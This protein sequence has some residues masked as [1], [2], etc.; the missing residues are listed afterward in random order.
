M[1][2]RIGPNLW[3]LIRDFWASIV[4]CFEGDPDLGRVITVSSPSRVE[5]FS[6]RITADEKEALTR[7]MRRHIPSSSNRVVGR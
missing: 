2:I 5:P 6:H 4:E 1:T 3:P 7:P